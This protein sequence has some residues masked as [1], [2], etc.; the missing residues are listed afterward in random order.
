MA[1]RVCVAG[2]T[3]WTGSAVTSAMLASNE[4][5]LVGAIARRQAGVDIGEALGRERANVII[6]ST[7]EEALATP[8]DVLVDYSSHDV[9][10]GHVLAALD[11]G[12]RV[13]VGTSGLTANNYAE[14]AERAEARNLGVIAAGNFSLTAALAKHFALI[15]AQYL[16]SWEIIDYASAAKVDAPSG[17]TR[18]LA[19][20]L[21]AI[22]QNQLGVPL[23]ETHGPKEVR[24]ATI[25]GTQVHSIRLP[26]YVIAFETIFGLPDERLTIRHDAGTGAQPYVSGTLLAVRKVQEVNGLV[27]GLDRLLFPGISAEDSGN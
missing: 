11:K 23:E 27:R 10:K 18:E 13:V 7:L 19:E 4:F 1:I 12:V 15:A 8:T 17:T 16:P 14:I 20:E 22:A 6:A 21:A 3:G 24:G 26:S 9:V 2:A 5:Q 25:G